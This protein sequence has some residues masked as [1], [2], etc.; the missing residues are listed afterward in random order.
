MKLKK[1]AIVG[2]PNTGKST[3][4]RRLA[5]R[6]ITV[7]PFQGTAVEI[8][9]GLARTGGEDT[10]LIDTPGIHS[11]VY[12]SEDGTV[13]KK[14]LIGERPDVIIQV[15]DAKDL[16]GSLVMTSLLA[17]LNI[18]M[19][20]VL[21]MV[22]E[23]EQ[24]GIK[25]KRHRLEEILGIDVIETV[26]SEGRGMKQL[27]KSLNNTRRP[28]IKVMFSKVIEDTI[29]A[30]EGLMPPEIS[31]KRA[32]A[33]LCISEDR[34]VSQWARDM[35]GITDSK[36]ACTHMEMTR[37][38]LSKPVD[39]VMARSRN[40][41][42]EEIFSQTVY[43][44]RVLSTPLMEKIG[45]LLIRPFAGMAALFA[46]LAAFYFIVGKLTAEYLVD[47]LDDHVFAAIISPR[48][49]SA[50]SMI[51]SEFIREAITGQYGIYTMGVV[52]AFGLVL[53]VITVFYF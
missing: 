50:V 15:A 41:Y 10:E 20:F 37:T 29:S 40:Q 14:I 2:M 7:S 1:I 16:M 21:N 4:F 26:A 30:V 35:G 9:R 44:T 11:L 6:N 19:I 12:Q 28:S 32:M 8:R 18:P 3:L 38:L 27:L 43:F 5:K 13:T 33:M 23:A 31:A 24:R 42:A 34:E 51:P 36:E 47:Y 17:D 46:L 45:S 53:P 39:I 25:V 48:L 49:D 22:D 52:P